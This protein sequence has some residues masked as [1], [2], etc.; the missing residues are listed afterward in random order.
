MFV[1]LECLVLEAEELFLPSLLS[2]CRE[3]C[4]KQVGFYRIIYY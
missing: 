4:V 3:L 1:P 2:K